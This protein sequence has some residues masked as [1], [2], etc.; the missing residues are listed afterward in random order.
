MR[1]SLLYKFSC[2]QCASTYIGLTRRMLRTRVA[3]HAGRSYRTGVILD[4]PPHTAVREA[5]GCDVGVVLDNCSILNS[6][7]SLLD[8]R[9]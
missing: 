3:E 4:H 8:L 9:I 5:E 6:T 2:A 7:S 1:T